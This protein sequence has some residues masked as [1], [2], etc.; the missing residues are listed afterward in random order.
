M[1]SPILHASVTP[2]P[3]ESSNVEPSFEEQSS[4]YEPTPT[5]VFEHIVNNVLNIPNDDHPIKLAIQANFMYYTV[6]DFQLFTDEQFRNMTY[7]SS[8]THRVL[9]LLPGASQLLIKFK[10]F[11]KVVQKNS[12]DGILSNRQWLDITHEDFIRYIQTPEV[13]DPDG[14]CATPESVTSSSPAPH[15]QPQF[16][17]QEKAV[18]EFRKGV[19]REVSAFPKLTDEKNW[20]NFHR[21]I[22]IIA[23]TQG[24]EDFLNP[25]YRPRSPDERALWPE[26]QKYAY[27]VLHYILLTDKGKSILREHE[28]DYNAQLFWGKFTKH[29]TSS[30]KA[31]L[32]HTSL[33]QYITT[34]CIDT[35]WSGTT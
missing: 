13:L 11:M 24:I 4:G 22:V 35:R 18:M 8:T 27:G 30:V 23:R 15:A 7:A 26:I 25:N 2:G 31:H 33:L 5:D 20:D 9:S 19:R 1:T 12:P 32:K 17:K 6:T 14:S 10:H 28:A 3:L 16:S 29:M 21:S 34:S